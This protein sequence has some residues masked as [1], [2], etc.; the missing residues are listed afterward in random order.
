MTGKVERPGKSKRQKIFDK[1]IA[2]NATWS[3]ISFRQLIPGE[4][5]FFIQNLS[6]RDNTI[7]GTKIMCTLI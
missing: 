6:S 5:I 2:L 7:L 4:S 3:K 1:R